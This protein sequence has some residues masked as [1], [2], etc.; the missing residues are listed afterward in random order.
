MRVPKSW[1]N[2]YVKVDD[3][4]NEYI[5]NKLF[6]CGFEVEEIIEINKNVK[7]VVTCKLIEKNRHP[8]A[9]KLFV[10]SVDAGKYGILQIVT[11]ATNV[12]VGDIVPV[13]L[14][15]AVLSDGTVIKK[16]KLRGVES[17]GMFCG[18]EEIG[19]TDEYYDG[20]SNDSVL[21]FNDDFNLG[22]DVAELLGIK[23]TVFDVSVT[24]NRPD[25]QSILGIAREVGAVLNRPLTLPDFSYKCGEIST[26]DMVEVENLDTDLCSRYMAAYVSDIKIEPSPKW[27][28]KRLALMGVR[29]INNIVDITNYVLN[30]IGQPMHAFDYRELEDNKII[31]RRATDG[32][33]I[34]TLDEK[35][36]TLSNDNLVI[37]DGKKPSALAGIMGGAGSG[38]KE[39]TSAIVFESARFK[40]DNIR[41]TSRNLGQR[42]D[43]SARFEKGVDALSCE[44]GLTRALNL[45][46]ALNA[47][48]VCKDYTDLNSVSMNKNVVNTTFK[49][50]EGLLGVKVQENVVVDILSRLNFV[51]KAEGDNLEVEVPLYRED[52]ES[53]PDLCE[54]I[55]RMYGY[56]HITSKL[57]D[58][59]TITIGGRNE[60]QNKELIAKNSLVSSG[61]NEIITYSF[62]SP[63]DFENFGFN[64]DDIQPIKLFN[65][66]GEDLSLMR[67][68]LIPSMVN[69][70][71]RNLSKKNLSG[72]LFELAKVYLA[73][74]LPLKELPHEKQVLAL[75]AFG[76]GEDFFTMKG[77]IENLLTAVKFSKN[78]SVEKCD[79]GFMHP[80]RSA[81]LITD[82]GESFG[83][84]G[85]LSPIISEK[86]GIDKRIYIAELDYEKLSESFD[87]AICFKNYSKYPSVE[88]DLALVCDGEISNRSV[89]DT[90]LSAN[91]RNLIDVSLFDV[92]TGE[93]IEKGKKSLAYR[94]TFSSEEKTLSVEEVDAY[95]KKILKKLNEKG[96]VLR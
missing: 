51:C 65:P 90:I 5:K 68:T 38:I 50:I 2:D 91:V 71:S 49:Q 43:S 42:S 1:L 95:I 58:N 64:I 73:K 3:L 40:R 32:E 88:R 14:C 39:D 19:I 16:G 80:S 96:I 52:V 59:A 10:C 67:T 54:E 78:Y 79:V 84:F 30:E 8:D 15:D 94:L 21:I 29:A 61:F 89:V 11:N 69:A 72:K 35:E 25:C 57:L 26:K 24:A 83:Y 13:A 20:A 85:E 31:I 81:S 45:I 6:S 46:C 77:Y 62:I 41:K 9:E 82:N 23:D 70:V 48:T 36:F 87:G 60:L 47:G 28:Q 53:Y 66:L 7:N 27:M 22:E 75:S 74:E 63:K 33:K 44:L 37:C 92:Y 12:Q 55:I 18:G 34:V 86:L 17:F 93:R 56:D 4:D 76:D